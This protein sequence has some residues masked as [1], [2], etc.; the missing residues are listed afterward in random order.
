VRLSNVLNLV[1][2]LSLAGCN[3]KLHIEKLV[4]IDPTFQSYVNDFVREGKAV[5]K[6]IVIDNLS[7]HFTNNLTGETLGECFSYNH[8]TD[9]T[10]LILINSQDWLAEIDDYKR[11]VMFHEMGHC[12]LWREHITTF[13]G[14]FGYITSIMFPYIQN[15]VSIYYSNWSYYMK[16]LFY[17]Q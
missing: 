15:D 14:P 5:G 6:N 7:I 13:N 17:G 1:L 4:S 8:G 11:I 3:T 10:P 12:V 9:G 2:L 16:E